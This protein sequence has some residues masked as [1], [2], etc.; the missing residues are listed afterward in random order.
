[1][2]KNND[3]KI[4]RAYNLIG[5]KIKYFRKE[6]DISQKELADKIEMSRTSLVQIENGVQKIQIDKLYQIADV[7]NITVS[8]LIPN[9]EEIKIKITSISNNE[10]NPT[11]IK[12]VIDIINRRKSND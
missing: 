1:M 6:K 8:D 12:E 4:E 3:I 9:E 7:L 10:I 11:D 5:Q 2:K